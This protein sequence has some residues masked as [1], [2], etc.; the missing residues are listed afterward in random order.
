MLLFDLKCHT[1]KLVIYCNHFIDMKQWD[2][3]LTGVL[4]HYH[5]CVSILWCGLI[6]ASVKLCVNYFHLHTYKTFILHCLKEQ[7][8]ARHLFFLL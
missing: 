1:N 7:H 2:K 5:E 6:L 8:T 3:P 4:I